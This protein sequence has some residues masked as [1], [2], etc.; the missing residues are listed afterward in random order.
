MMNLKKFSIPK[1]L[2][3]SDT[4][5]KVTIEG[6]T[7]ERG[8][9]EYNLALGE[10]RANAVKNY[11]VENGIDVSRLKTVSFG[12]ERSAFFGATEEIFGKN[13]RA[14]TVIN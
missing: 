13:R 2:G 4:N 8:T 12:K 6:H 7:D 10:K 14:V 9:R 11:L 3:C 5:I 1:L